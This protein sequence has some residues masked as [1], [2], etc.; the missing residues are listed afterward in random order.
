M[1]KYHA[2]R[3]FIQYLRFDWFIYT[4]YEYPRIYTSIEICSYCDF[5]SYNNGLFIINEWVYSNEHRF[6]FDRKLI[7]MVSHFFLS[8]FLVGAARFFGT[9][10]IWIYIWD[11]VHFS[12]KFW[13]DE[14]T[15]ESFFDTLRAHKNVL[16]QWKMK[17]MMAI[18]VLWFLTNIQA[19]RLFDDSF[20]QRVLESMREMGNRNIKF[21]ITDKI[22]SLF[23]L[24]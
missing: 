7:W 6:L 23:L 9:Q 3:S 2:P 20:S 19:A 21:V 10:K 18:F 1:H 12:D 5:S 15:L 24:S 14:R 22:K 4:I 11:C 17:L 13:M 16:N 8:S